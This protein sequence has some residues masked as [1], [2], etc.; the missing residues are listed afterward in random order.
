MYKN[1]DD[2]RVHKTK[3]IIS[4]VDPVD[5]YMFM[6]TYT[7]FVVNNVVSRQNLYLTSHNRE[8]MHNCNDAMSKLKDDI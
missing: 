1:A 8:V 5:C 7:E 4:Y 2:E 3:Y 6:C